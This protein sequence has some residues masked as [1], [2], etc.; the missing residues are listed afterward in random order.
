[1]VRGGR[2]HAQRA[3][4][5][6]PAALITEMV[7]LLRLATYTVVVRGLNTAATG[8]APTL[9]FAITWPQPTVTVALHRAPSNTVT[10][11]APVGGMLTTYTVSV[12]VSITAA[13]GPPP[14]GP[15]MPTLARA[16]TRQ[17]ALTLLLQSAVLIT[18][19]TLLFCSGT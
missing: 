6:H 16:T 2:P 15:N 9:I 18:S 5:L 10:V 17:P 3:T 1:M 11:P 14:C 4:E 13:I 8:N 12:P 7:L 19:T